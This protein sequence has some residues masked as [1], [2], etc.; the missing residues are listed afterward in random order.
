[1]WNWLKKIAGD[2]DAYYWRR[3]ADDVWRRSY[4]VNC[5]TRVQNVLDKM[6]RAGCAADVVVGTRRTHPHIWIEFED[7]IIDPSGVTTKSTYNE[8]GRKTVTPG[9]S[10]RNAIRYVARKYGYADPDK[11]LF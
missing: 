5:V 8:V 9:E 6:L 11:K 1:M 4:S 7:M 3:V 10:S 2:E